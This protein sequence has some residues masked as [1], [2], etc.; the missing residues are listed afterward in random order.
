MTAARLTS[1]AQA[2]LLSS[3]KAVSQ[4]PRFQ[5]NRSNLRGR[6]GRRYCERSCKS[7]LKERR[8]NRQERWKWDTGYCS[9]RL[10]DPSGTIGFISWREF[11]HEVGSL[12]KIDRAQ[13]RRFRDTP[14]INIGDLTKIEPFHDSSFASMDDLQSV[15]RSTISNCETEPETSR[16]QCR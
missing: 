15:N 7:S 11:N 14:E 10:A 8:S 5:T 2:E 6:R 13:I 4:L 16:L 1:I 3:K 12:I 9:G